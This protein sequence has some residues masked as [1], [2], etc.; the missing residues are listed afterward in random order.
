MTQK[1]GYV[2]SFIGFC[3][4][5]QARILYLNSIFLV[6]MLGSEPIYNGLLWPFLLESCNL[7]IYNIPWNFSQGYTWRRMVVK[8]L[9]VMH[10]Q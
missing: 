1:H 9:L 3:N 5:S 7:Q 2:P 10:N 8:D 6:A 4:V